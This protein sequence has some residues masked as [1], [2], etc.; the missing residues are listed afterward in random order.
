MII[1]LAE[2]KIKY[3]SKN[4]WSWR[5]D[6]TS[7]YLMS[8]IWVNSSRC[9]CLPN[10]GIM[11]LMEMEI[12][13]LIS[14]CT[15]SIRHIEGFS[16]SGIL[17][18]I[19]KSRTRL[20]EKQQQEEDHRKLHTDANANTNANAECMKKIYATRKLCQNAQVMKRQNFIK[21]Y[22]D[23]TCINVIYL[24]N[25]TKCGHQYRLSCKP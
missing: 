13:I 3:L 2:K 22:F 9:T 23:K 17:I 7:T 1:A 15:A 14:I 12:T 25:C 11:D 18:I 4:T 21:S 16:K 19:L 6:I 10:L 24:I 5:D 20:T 8:L